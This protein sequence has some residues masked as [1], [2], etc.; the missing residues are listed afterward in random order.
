MFEIFTTFI[1]LI[2]VRNVQ[3]E[4]KY[5]N[6]LT[7]NFNV[8]TLSEEKV[9]FRTFKRFYQRYVF[10]TPKRFCILLKKGSSEFY[11][12]PMGFCTNRT[13]YQKKWFYRTILKF[14]IWSRGWNHF[15]LICCLYIIS[16]YNQYICAN[17]NKF[18]SGFLDELAVQNNSIYST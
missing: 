3:N 9:L 10:G 13:F 14:H 11:I 5:S 1:C 8:S 15:L 6:I 17:C 4:T 12:E 18:F 16:I 2:L 7:I